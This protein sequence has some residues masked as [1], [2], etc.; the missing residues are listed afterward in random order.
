[1]GRGRVGRALDSKF[2][3][4]CWVGGGA[5]EA[6]GRAGDGEAA[7]LREGRDVNVEPLTGEELEVLVLFA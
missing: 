6:G 2:E 7:G 5:E 1:M 4:G 3:I